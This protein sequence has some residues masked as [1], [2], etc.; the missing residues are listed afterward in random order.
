VA[1]PTV[2]KLQL[3][4]ELRRLRE[5]AGRTPAEA[6]KIIDCNVTKIS[7]LETAQSGIALGD[8]KLLL[9]FYGDEPEHI[10]WM[11][12]LSRGNTER[13]RW[14]GHRAGVPEWFRAYVDLERD[15]E[16]IRLTEVELVPGL[17]Q[18][19]AYARALFEEALPFGGPTD[20]DGAVQSRLERRQVLDREDAPTLSCVLSE[21]CVRRTVGGRAVMAEQLRHLAD[22]AGR[23]RIQLQLRPFDDEAPSG[24]I[25]HRFT[26][27]R[28]PTP[29]EAPPLAF[30]YCED[31]DNARYIDDTQTVRAYEALWNS[32]QAAALSPT[33]TR[34][35]LRELARQL[36]EGPPDVPR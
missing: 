6:A 17:L 8:L 3:G 24:V 10:E 9:E 32:M 29:G 23:P 27:V 34:R 31:F 5:A 13:G 7:R 11:I 1:T 22:L 20:V 12:A 36:T 25:V 4:N 18:T 16:D 14:V 26:M 2:R 21:S 33:E 15:A 19:G 30:I 28:I 35:R